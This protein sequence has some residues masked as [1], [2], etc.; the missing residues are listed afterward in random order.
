MHIHTCKFT[1]HTNLGLITEATKLTDSN[2]E[3]GWQ[4]TKHQKIVF[5]G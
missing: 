4:I 3:T 2:R 5:T 1:K